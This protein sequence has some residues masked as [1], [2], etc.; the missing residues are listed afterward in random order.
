MLGIARLTEDTCLVETSAG[1]IEG[2]DDR[3]VPGICSE[4]GHAVI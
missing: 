3:R 2:E 4:M 1:L